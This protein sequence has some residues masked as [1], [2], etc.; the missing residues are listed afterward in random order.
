MEK[1][2]SLYIVIF[3]IVFILFFIGVISLFIQY[4]NKQKLAIKEKEMLQQKHQQELLLAQLDMQTQTMQEIGREI[5]DNV[6]QKLTLASLYTQQLDYDN[7][8]PEITERVNSISNIIN[9]SLNELRSLSKN[10]TN[11]YIEEQ[12]LKELLENEIEKIKQTNHYQMETSI[13]H[14]NGYTVLTKTI[15]LRVVQEFFQ[16][17]MKHAHATILSLRLQRKSNGLYLD[18][19]DNG[20]GFDYNEDTSQKG[21]GLQNMKKRIALVG[22]TLQIQSGV[23]NG[24]NL[25]LFIPNEKL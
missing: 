13:D 9:E 5:H 15:I 20:K 14:T 18:L 16:N 19:K 2:L 24:T 22:G 1:N 12:S 10:L 4:K 6:G 3:F 25:S 17:A 7:K 8:Y 23:N 11:S 21:I